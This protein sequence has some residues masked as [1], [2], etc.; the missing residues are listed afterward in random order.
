[1]IGSPRMQRG[2]LRVEMGFSV[3]R[4]ITGMWMMDDCMVA[5]RFFFRGMQMKVGGSTC[6]SKEL[7]R[8]DGTHQ[9]LAI[10]AHWMRLL[11]QHGQGRHCVV[12]RPI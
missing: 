5:A 3:T 1:M 6:S 9:M 12:A 8:C 11:G 4:V 2:F 7:R 10:R